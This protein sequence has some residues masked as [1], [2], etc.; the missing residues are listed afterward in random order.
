MHDFYE[1][2]GAGIHTAYFGKV[3]GN[4]AKILRQ[5]TEDDDR[6]EGGIIYLLSGDERLAYQKPI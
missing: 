4:P 5:L 3:V 6:F 2:F 1:N